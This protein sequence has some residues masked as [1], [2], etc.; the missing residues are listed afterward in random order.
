MARHARL[1]DTNHPITAGT[2]GWFLNPAVRDRYPISYHP[3]TIQEVWNDTDFISIHWYQLNDPPYGDL[4]LALADTQTA[5][6]PVLLEEIGQADGGYQDN[7]QPQPWNEAWVN[8][9]T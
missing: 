9:W 3:E 2:Y 7:C 5:G 8:N 6:K 4:N 1:Y